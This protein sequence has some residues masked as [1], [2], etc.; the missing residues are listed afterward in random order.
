MFR[1]I[2]I[3]FNAFIIVLA[4]IGFNAI[5]GQKYIE[6]AKDTVGNFIARHN[7]E[8]AKKIGDFS[9]LNEEFQIDNT[10]SLMGYK[11]VI[12]EHKASGQKMV[13]L[14]SGKKVLLTQE[15][16]NSPEIDKK[17]KNLSEKFKYQGAKV[18]DIKVT[19]RGKIDVYGQNVP[20]AK[21]DAKIT[22][23]PVSDVSGII[24]VVKTSD[25][26]EKLTVAL[27]EKKKYSQLITNEFYR[28]VSEGVNS[29]KEVK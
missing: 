5:G 29:V 9:K 18:Q 12:A 17:L 23:L 3:I 16:I 7:F 4:I 8:N 28:G 15:D 22:K 27:N 11:A 2:R 1:L 6:M 24:A 20:Y 21:F 13:I 10:M 19:N 25:N 26:S 14:D